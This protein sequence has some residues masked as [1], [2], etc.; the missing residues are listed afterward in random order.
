MERDFPTLGNIFSTKK[1][2]KM[3]K[4]LWPHLFVHASLDVVSFQMG[5]RSQWLVPRLYLDS[6][7]PT[8]QIL[9]VGEL[10][11]PVATSATASSAAVVC[12]DLFR[13]PR[14]RLNHSALLAAFLRHG[15]YTVRGGSFISPRPRVEF[16]VDP[17]LRHFLRNYEEAVFRQA[18]IEAG[19]SAEHISFQQESTAP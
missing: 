5:S 8:A 16:T 12:V 3:M 9:G 2:S 13:E 1:E 10:A 11:E 15:F 6:E 18:A 7:S 19:A 4:F 17:A 14:L